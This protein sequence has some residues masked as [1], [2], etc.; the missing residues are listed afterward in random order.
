[1]SLTQDEFHQLQDYIANSNPGIPLKGGEYNRLYE[2]ID[3]GGRGQDRRS[4]MED[5]RR[6]IQRA[7]NPVEDSTCQL[8]TGFPGT[9]KT[10]ELYRLQQHLQ[11]DKQVP[12]HVVLVDFEE[13]IDLYAPIAVTDVLRVLA[14]ALD[15]EASMQEALREGKEFDSKR[16]GYLKKIF[17]TVASFDP[18]IKEIGFEAYGASLMLEIKEN[19]S[20]RK[21]VNDALDLRFQVFAK[22]A[23]D[24]MTESLERL[25]RTT[26]AVRIVI[27]ADSLEKLTYTRDEV[28]EAT[29]VAAETVFVTHSELLRIGTH[30]IYTFPFWLRFRTPQI[31]G[32]YDNEPRILPMVKISTPEGTPYLAGIQALGR[33]V[34]K[35]MP[36]DKVF[37][38][39]DNQKKTLLPLVQA[40]GGY[41][42]DLLRMIREVLHTTDTLPVTPEDCITV[43]DRLGQTYER[44]LRATDADML[45]EIA[46]THQIPDGDA[47]RVGAFSRLF[48][49][50]FVLAYM[51]G[52]EWYDVHPLVRRART[53]TKRLAASS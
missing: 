41:F 31:C 43:I 16:V 46:T 27:I 13:F 30:V 47:N 49:H 6:T 3:Q 5:L 48:S 22:E 53:M 12:T 15:R 21:R 35:R 10:T 36:L 1:M 28:R 20:F 24:D 2:P 44:A 45:V 50:H 17:D 23:R 7:K 19:G 52:Y 40:S 51:N 32:L 38:S 4:V 18:Q 25:R 29:E 39:D 34:N 26:H 9:G 8:F 42:R 37:G 11:S 14:Y 33:L